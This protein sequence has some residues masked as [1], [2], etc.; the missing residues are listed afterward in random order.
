MAGAVVAGGPGPVQHERHAGLVQGDVHQ[1][2]VEG[3]VQER[4]V[5]R[6]HGVQAAE[7]HAGGA[8]GPVLLGDADVDD[9]VGV[10]LGEALE[11][12]RDE[13]GGG[14]GDHVLPLAADGDHLVG[15]DGGP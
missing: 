2:L 12:D 11:A 1:H 4:R 7:R 13:H 3:A 6:H 15:E 8:G 10:R 9:P 14:D 5:D